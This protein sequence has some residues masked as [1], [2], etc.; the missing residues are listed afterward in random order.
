M[1]VGIRWKLAGAFF[2]V[3]VVTL[4]ITGGFLL[5]YLEGL[6]LQGRE[7]T[8]LAHASI[9]AVAGGEHLLR[10]DR[11]AVYLARDYGDQIGARLLFIDQDGKVA[12]DSFGEGWLEGRQLNHPEVASALAGVSR[13]GSYR[14]ADG[15]RVLYV[16]VPV[17]REKQVH[18]VVMVIAGV[19]DIYA[20]LAQVRT[21][22]VLFTLVAG[23]LAALFSLLLSTGLTRPMQELT[24]VV[25][26]TARGDPGSQV[27]VRSRDE[28]GQLAAAFNTM[29]EQLAKVET[30]R[31]E[32]IANVSHELKSP[33]ASVKALAQSLAYGKEQDAA[34]YRE[35]LQDID[36][37]VDRL[38]RLVDD[39]LQLVRLDQ[40]GVVVKLVEQP[41]RPVV[42]RV[43]DLITP[44]AI[45]AGVSLEIEADEATKWPL[46]ADLVVQ[47]VF[48]LVDNGIKYTPSGG[49][50]TVAALVQG[51][52]LLLRVRDTGEGIGPEQ[53]QHVFDRFYRVDKARTRAT[54]GTGLGLS[55]VRQSVRLHGGEVEVDSAPGRGTVFTL[56]LPREIKPL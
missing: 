53:L 17:V 28:V 46:D 20:T 11:N 25:E 41:V 42:G 31:R 54:G 52:E 15:E 38:N 14:L 40:G 56:R 16:A 22:L 45:S 37:E 34:V 50:V 44:L 2:A 6:Y 48:N 23:L 9:I 55:I 26:R 43:V 47:M 1:G 12:V 7:S 21:Q 36:G 8:Y 24:R 13:A 35:Y 3:I 39:L 51:R 32:F 33:L 4:L 19:N 5:R 27:L 29:S 49:K 10:Y 18:G 30:A